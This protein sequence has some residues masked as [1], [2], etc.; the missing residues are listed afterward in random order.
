[1]FQCHDEPSR[2]AT[3]LAHFFALVLVSVPLWSAAAMARWSSASTT[4]ASRVGLCGYL[5]VPSAQDTEKRSGRE[6]GR[7]DKQV[8]G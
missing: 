3:P 6:G 7:V 4:L 1:M 8:T 5:S 2:S